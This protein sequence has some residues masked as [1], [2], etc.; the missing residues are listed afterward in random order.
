M[1]DTAEKMYS[2]RY[3][4]KNRKLF[5]LIARFTK[6]GSYERFFRNACAIMGFNACEELSKICCP[7]LIIAGSDDLTVGNEAPHTLHNGIP[8]SRMHIYQGLGHG[9]FE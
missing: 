9:A 5:P 2:K 4:E 6:P 1:V 7:T 8:G 3:L